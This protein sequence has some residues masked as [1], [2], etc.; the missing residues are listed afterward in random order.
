MIATH[1]HWEEDE[2]PE[3]YEHKNLEAQLEECQKMQKCG[4]LHQRE[5]LQVPQKSPTM[6]KRALL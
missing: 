6:S 3:L 4:M 2:N 5:E 1:D